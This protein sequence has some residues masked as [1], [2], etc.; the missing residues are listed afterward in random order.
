MRGILAGSMTV[1]SLG[2]ARLRVSG[3]GVPG[4]Q[5]GSKIAVRRASNEALVASGTFG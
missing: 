4:V 2:A 1:N 3:N 5:T